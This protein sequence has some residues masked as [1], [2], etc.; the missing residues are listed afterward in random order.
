[1]DETDIGGYEQESFWAYFER[2]SS[3]S[4]IPQTDIIGTIVF[5]LTA[6]ILP[7][8]PLTILQREALHPAYPRNSQK[9]A[10]AYILL[11]LHMQHHGHTFSLIA[12]AFPRHSRAK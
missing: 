4:D 11:S 1:M 10:C 9:I 2:L 3:V 8:V 12:F 7:K 6:I 5:Y